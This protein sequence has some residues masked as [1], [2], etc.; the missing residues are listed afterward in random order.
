M[1]TEIVIGKKFGVLKITEELPNIFSNGRS[2]RYVRAV[3]ECGHIGEWRLNT[4]KKMQSCGCKTQEI[5]IKKATIHGL[6]GHQLYSH[7][8]NM[9]NRCYNQKVESYV[10]CGSKGIHVCKKWKH[11]FKAFYDWSILNG[12]EPGLT[13]DRYPNKNGDYSPDN[14]RWAN[15]LQQANN[16][17]TNILYTYKGETKTLAEFSHKYGF[18]YKKVHTRI[19]KLKWD[20][21][22]AFETA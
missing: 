21:K 12:W 8:N 4:L 18:N 13:L 17:N 11:N 2:F 20:I 10:Y 6:T 5:I 1:N 22:T 14:C 15:D 9:K 3:C 7:W 16:K 19:K